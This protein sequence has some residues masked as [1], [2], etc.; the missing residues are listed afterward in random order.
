M[1][2]SKTAIDSIDKLPAAAQKQNAPLKALLDAA[3]K[4]LAQA[5][6]AMNEWMNGF[7]YDSL[8]DNEA[9]RVQYLQNE[10]T[11]INAVKDLVLNSLSK[12]DS[13]LPKNKTGKPAMRKGIIA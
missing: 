8:K 11:K 12:A 4:D 2:E 1:K 10:K 9:A 6:N 7:K 5:D 13:L 3:H